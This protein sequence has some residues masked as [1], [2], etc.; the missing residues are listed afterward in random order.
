MGESVESARELLTLEELTDRVG[1]SVRNVRFYT[2]K[3]LVP[4]PVRRGRSGYYTP[5]HVARLELVRELQS[6]G[7]T[8]AAIERYLRGIPTGATPEDIALHR[9]MLA[10]WQSEAPV[11]MTRA[12]LNRRANRTLT[13][14]DLAT[15]AALG[16]ALRDR[17]GRFEVAGSQLSVGL[18][19]LDLGFP[20]EAAVAAADVYAEHG[21]QIAKE[22]YDLFRTMVWPAYKESGASPEKL[23]EVVERL[24][25]LSIASLVAAY[26]SAM[27]EEKR[28]GIARRSRAQSP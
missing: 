2:T 3:G 25:P 12:E 4:P 7:F 28:E 1:L 21:R 16:I 19:L 20:T 9:T 24:K 6:H 23:R 10:P 11:V 22:L 26:E 17:R 27:D 15:L 13:D 14:E 8:L 18:G 5:D